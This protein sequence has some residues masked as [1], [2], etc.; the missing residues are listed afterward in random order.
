MAQLIQ[1]IQLQA[2]SS[3]GEMVDFTPLGASETAPEKGYLKVVNRGVELGNRR[4][5]VRPHHL[6]RGGAGQRDC[7]EIPWETMTITRR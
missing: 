6:E 2:K 4:L 3:T 5:S 7:L 1:G